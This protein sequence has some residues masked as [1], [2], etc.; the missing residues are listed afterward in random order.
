LLRRQK[1]E[2][3][4]T[5]EAP[6]QPV[7]RRLLVVDDH[8]EAGHLIAQLLRRADFEVAELGD[9]QST[10]SALVDHEGPVG[11]VIA[12]FTTT[13][14]SG[15]LRLID[16]LRNHHLDRINQLR[17]LLISDQPRQ[18]L[19]CLQAGADAILMRPFSGV[20]LVETVEAMVARPDSERLAYR[21]AMVDEVKRTWHQDEPDPTP[22]ACL[23]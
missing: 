10:V 19:F 17:V 1:T 12:S 16:A 22:A 5:E 13:G 7:S 15:G 8:A 14:T 20:E 3:Q 2:S 11:G 4:T 6:T 23:S 21:R 9:H 18:Q